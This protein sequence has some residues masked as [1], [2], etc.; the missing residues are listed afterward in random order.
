MECVMKKSEKHHDPHQ[1][2]A[3]GTIGYSGQFRFYIPKSEQTYPYP[4]TG[5]NSNILQNHA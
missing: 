4:H 5:L 2:L 3:H 1:V